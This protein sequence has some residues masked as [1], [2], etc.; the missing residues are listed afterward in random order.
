MILGMIKNIHLGEINNFFIAKNGQL[1]VFP[2]SFSSPNDIIL[3]EIK[4]RLLAV[5]CYYW[6]LLLLLVLRVSFNKSHAFKF[7]LFWVLFF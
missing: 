5:V 7:R 6:L 1:W 4:H 3:S 2:S